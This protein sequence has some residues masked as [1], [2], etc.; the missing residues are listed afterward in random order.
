M[1][2]RLLAYNSMDV[3]IVL[4]IKDCTR[5]KKNKKAN[6]LLILMLFYHESS[7]LNCNS[8]E[9]G[10]FL[11]VISLAFFPCNSPVEVTF[12]IFLACFL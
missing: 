4:F 11:I 6:L 3:L 2:S 5:E 12:F 9:K 10:T 7:L 1:F 8:L